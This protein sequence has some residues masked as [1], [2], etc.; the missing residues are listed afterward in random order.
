MNRPIILG[1]R[2]SALALAQVELLKTALFGAFPDLQIGVKKITTSG[3]RRSEFADVKETGA[4]VKGLFTKEIENALLDGSID[5]AVHSC[6]DLPG[7]L[8]EGLEV[9]AVLEREDTADVFI[10][11]EKFSKLPAGATIGTGSV[12]RR[13]QLLWLRPDLKIVELRGNVPTRIEKL[14][15]SETLAGI[16]LARAGLNRLGLALDGWN[17]ETLPVLHAIGQGAVA[18]ECRTGDN[19]IA[20]LLAFVNHEPTFRCIRAERE[21]LR[22]LNGDCHLP[23][24]VVTKLD[25]GALSLQTIIFGNEG[26]PPQT[27]MESG[28]ADAPE[29]IATK[30]FER[31]GSAH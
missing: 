21:L 18:L 27:G 5:I 16:V 4:G 15:A 12:R 28:P 20:A 6:K 29:I 24:G 8:T 7:R 25:E 23:V 13:R 1:T 3:D 10:S 30:L 14:R 11:R 9:R 22:L 17:V 2:G 31:M 19:E 26:E